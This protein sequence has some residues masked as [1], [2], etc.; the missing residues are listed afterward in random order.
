MAHDFK[1]KEPTKTEKVLYELMIAQQH[2]ERGLWST[3]SV[4]MALAMISGTDPVK[5]AQT[6]LDEDKIREFSSK[7]NEEIKKQEAL[8]P[9]KD[10][11]AGHNHPH[12]EESEQI[13]DAE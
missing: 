4:V 2:T 3:S 10:D 13:K 11:H 8:K 1:H 7:V 9:K 5:L 6:I 12:I